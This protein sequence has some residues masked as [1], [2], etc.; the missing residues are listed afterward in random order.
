VETSTDRPRSSPRRLPRTEPD[1]NSASA[2]VVSLAHNDRSLSSPA[3]LKDSHSEAVLRSRIRVHL[4]VH[5]DEISKC[6]RKLS[7]FGR[8]ERIDPQGVLESGDDDREGER[9]EAGLHE[10][11]IVGEFRQLVTLLGGNLL[12]L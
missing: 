1:A 8:A 5:L 2:T 4:L 7:I 10:R 11:P 12:E 9:I 3:R 6:H